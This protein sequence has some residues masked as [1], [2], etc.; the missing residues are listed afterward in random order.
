MLVRAGD[1]EV[2]VEVQDDGVGPGGA[3]VTSGL[4]NL[5]RRAQDLG[6]HLEFSPGPGGVGTRVRW[7]VPTDV[8][9]APPDWS[10]PPTL[11]GMP[12]P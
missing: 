6:G 12:R 4:A 11:P 9:P 8:R 1:D 5:R 2:L 3:T 10:S 7:R